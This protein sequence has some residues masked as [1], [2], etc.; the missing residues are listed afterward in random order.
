VDRFDVGYVLNNKVISLRS[1]EDIRD[2]MGSAQK[3]DNILL[4]CDGL[5]KEPEKNKHINAKPSRQQLIVLALMMKILLA[6]VKKKIGMTKL[7]IVLK[8]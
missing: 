7:S 2:L 5:R 8:N 4:W 1:K 6:N 3:G